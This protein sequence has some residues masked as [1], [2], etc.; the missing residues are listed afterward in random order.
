VS[1]SAA[2]TPSENCRKYEF[3]GSTNDGKKKRPFS[4]RLLRKILLF[5]LR[6]T[7]ATGFLGPHM[8]A[9]RWRLMKGIKNEQ[10]YA[11]ALND[12]SRHAGGKGQG[13]NLYL[14]VLVHLPMR[15][16]NPEARPR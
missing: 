13:V 14:L 11:L 6:N 4:R 16:A 15:N 2:R 7:G 10:L 1:D 9:E 8:R 3:L 5:L 12:P